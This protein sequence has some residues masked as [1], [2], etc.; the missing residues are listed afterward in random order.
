MKMFKYIGLLL[1]G[2]GCSDFLSDFSLNLVY[3]N[4][5][6]DLEEMLLGD[7][8]EIGV[9]DPRDYFW[10]SNFLTDN[11]KA[12]TVD[13]AWTKEYEKFKEVYMWNPDMFT[14]KYTEQDKYDGTNLWVVPYKSILG[15]NI[16]LD[17]LDKMEGDSNDREFL[18]GEA[19]ALRSWYYLL[20]VNW[21]GLPYSKGNPETDLGVPLKLESGVRDEYMERSTVGE[22]YNQIENDLLQASRLM[23]D[24]AKKIPDFRLSHLGAWAILSRV[25]LYEGKWN[26]AIAWADSVLNENDFLLDLNNVNN[27]D[28][29]TD[30]YVSKEVIWR[31]PYT[32]TRKNYG[33]NIYPY[34]VSDELLDA[35]ETTEVLTLE[36]KSNDLRARS[37]IFGARKGL[38]VSKFFLLCPLHDEL[39]Y[40]MGI[41][42]A[43]LYLNRAEAYAQKFIEERD[44]SYRQKALD[45]INELRKHR[46]VHEDEYEEVNITDGQ[47]LLDYCIKERWRELCADYNHRWCDLRRYGLTVTHRLPDEDIAET[48][49][50]GEYALPIPEQVMNENPNLVQNEY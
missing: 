17:H 49:N 46:L 45:N 16:V 20:L 10:I 30:V 13:P 21:F 24:H 23:K 39:T 43:E 29:S 33:N 27:D 14:I 18:R 1:L 22:V 50:M 2:C 12:T 47:Q 41:R 4:T 26:L 37:Y 32:Q 40:Y 9:S 19:L 38:T 5:V 42:T 11:L 44:V 3:P 48:K 7:G 35:Y 25:Y 28:R 36:N 6:N 31:R 15:C 8:Y 34:L